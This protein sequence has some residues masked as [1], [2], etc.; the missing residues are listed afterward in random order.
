MA[1]IEKDTTWGVFFPNPADTSPTARAMAKNLLENIILPLLPYMGGR[2]VL[3]SGSRTMKGIE[4][5]EGEGY[6]PSRTSDHL[7]G[8]IEPTAGAGDFIPENSPETFFAWVKKNCDRATGEIKLPSGIVV[9]VGQIILEKNRTSWC[10]IS[11]PRRLFWP[12]AGGLTTLLQSDD[13]GKTY[14]EV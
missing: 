10:H 2:C 12:K 7:F 3:S 14:R 11:N 8:A 4:R 6:H 1:I 9:K 5:L 13:N